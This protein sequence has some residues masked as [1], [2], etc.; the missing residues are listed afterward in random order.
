MKKVLLTA[1]V[2]GLTMFITSPVFSSEM[3]NAELT[4][5]IQ[6]LEKKIEQV[7]LNNFSDKINV[8]GV[9]EFEASYEKQDDSSSD[10]STATVD[11]G[12]EGKVNDY[13]TGSFVFTYEEEDGGI[14]LDEAVIAISKENSP[15]YANLGYYVVPFGVFNTRFISDPATL[16]LGETTENTITAGYETD[17]FNVS[18]SIFNGDI[19]EADE[20]DDHISNYV[21]SGTINLEPV[22]NMSVSF[23]GSFISSIA[24]SDVLEEAIEEH[25]GD[26]HVKDITSGYSLYVSASFMDKFFLD[27]EY[28][29]A[30]DEIESGT[31]KKEPTAYNI[32]LGFAPDDKIEAAVR[33]EGTDDMEVETRYG[34]AAGYAV[35]DNT[36]LSVEY[37]RSEFEE[38]GVDDADTF[39]AQLAIEF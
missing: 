10:F 20:D 36:T 26:M 34:A 12:I 13:I 24:E 28:V 32:E 25:V 3:S 22:E 16:D 14:E 7:S 30:T 39:T 37:L 19:N 1:A 15:I 31:Y 35:L 4:E 18:A 38:K 2:F 17:L 33:Y 11:L 6:G 21:L 23:G 29:G 8:S 27:A 5:K 9:I